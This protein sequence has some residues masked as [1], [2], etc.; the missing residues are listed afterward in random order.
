MCWGVYGKVLE[1]HGERA[2]VDF[3]GVVEEVVS[4]VDELVPGDYVVVHAGMIISK[5]S[6]EEFLGSFKYIYEMAK[7]LVENGELSKRELEKMDEVVKRWTTKDR[8]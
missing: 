5:L 2:Y 4:V 8:W 3:G 7:K 6:E 1:V